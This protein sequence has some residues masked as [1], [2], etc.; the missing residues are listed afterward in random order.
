MSRLAR[1]NQRLRNPA[2]QGSSGG[3]DEAGASVLV[4]RYPSALDQAPTIGQRTPLSGVYWN[5]LGLLLEVIQAEIGPIA[6]PFKPGVSARYNL[7]EWLGNEVLGNAISNWRSVAK[8]QGG[9]ARGQIYGITKIFEQG[10]A[11]FFAGRRT[12]NKT[13]SQGAHPLGK[14]PVLFGHTSARNPATGVGH[15]A[16][17]LFNG[18][19]LIRGKADVVGS[20]LQVTYRG[21]KSS[22]G[23]PTGSATFSANLVA[24][25]MVEGV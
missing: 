21:A 7:A 5:Y 15:A 14:D 24:I 19:I 23:Q 22:G 10:T 2:R 13:L 18:P 20:T 9:N 8:A 6:F 11:T 4:P 25:Y 12:V 3:P 16:S 17:D 1:V